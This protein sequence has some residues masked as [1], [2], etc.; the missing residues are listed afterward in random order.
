MTRPYTATERDNSKLSR[1]E[2][3]WGNGEF[4]FANSS[5]WPSSQAVQSTIRIANA[6]WQL[7]LEPALG[8]RPAWEKGLMATAVLGALI[9]AVLVGTIM[10]SWA[11]Q[12]QLLAEV[13]VSCVG[14]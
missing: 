9:I 6:E 14:A 5:R 13:M 11:Q 12:Q 1:P 2:L 8:W 4:V 10:A 3:T 7:F